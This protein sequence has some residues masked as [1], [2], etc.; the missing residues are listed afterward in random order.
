MKIILGLVLF[1]FTGLLRAQTPSNPAYTATDLGTLGGSVSW[2]YGVNNMGQVVGSARLA[3]G[4][5]HA[6]LYSGTGN[7]NTDLAPLVTTSHAYAINDL[8]QI[9]GSSSAHGATLFSGTGSGN[10]YLA[11]SS[12]EAFGISSSGRIVGNISDR[13]TLFS[14][15]GSGNTDLGTLGGSISYAYSTNTSNITVGTARTAAS[16]QLAT[17]FSGTGSANTNL[18]TLGGTESCA[19][20]INNSN[21]IVGY[22]Y[23]AAGLSHAT[24]FSGTGSDNTDIGTLGGTL[25]QARAI[26]EYGQIVGWANTSS[27]VARAFI[28]SGGVMSNLN[29]L[30]TNASG[31]K[32]IY[33]EGYGNAINDW[34]QIAAQGT[35]GVNTHAVLLNPVNP[36]SFTTGNTTNVKYVS[37]MSYN[38]MTTT[39]TGNLA[40]TVRFLNGTAGS[41]GWVDSAAGGFGLNRDVTVAFTANNYDGFSSDFVNVSGTFSDVMVL[42]LSYTNSGAEVNLGWYDN[43]IWKLAAEGNSSAGS[44]AGFYNMAYTDFLSGHGGTFNA[45]TMLGAYGTSSVNST[46]WA[47]INHNSTFAVIPEPATCALF[48]LGALVFVV[49]NRSRRRSLNIS[50]VKNESVHL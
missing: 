44:L 10:T 25:S 29:S 49:A 22:A 33:L 13:A 1:G 35:V 17:L 47:V 28:Y 27:N 19:F 42:C 32:D 12:S 5:D 50:V 30:S 20:D 36:L 46:V 39:E 26:N 24:I 2:A 41:G 8:G 21:Q 31:I 18:G 16:I 34:G 48:A 4:Q 9:V 7:S 38:T 23:T 11:V 3:N 45:A 6:A 40:T 37:G 14:G 43:G 15:T